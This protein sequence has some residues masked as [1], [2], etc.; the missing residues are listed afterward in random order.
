M[1]A[2][3]LGI[4]RNPGRRTQGW[5]EALQLLFHIDHA[6]QYGQ[7]L[8]KFPL[9]IALEPLSFETSL[10]LDPVSPVIQHPCSW[11]MDKSSCRT[12]SS[13]GAFPCEM[14]TSRAS[15]ELVQFH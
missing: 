3:C 9:W 10:E 15:L 4:Q 13:E 11:L 6:P 1:Q 7:L 14:D 2:V 5:Q 8:E 12:G